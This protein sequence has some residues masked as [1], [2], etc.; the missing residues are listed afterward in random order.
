VTAG[1]SIATI[2]YNIEDRAERARQLIQTSCVVADTAPSAR[3]LIHRVIGDSGEK[4]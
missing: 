2:H 1:E 3:P 4:H